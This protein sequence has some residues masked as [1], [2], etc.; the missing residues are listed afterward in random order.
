MKRLIITIT[1]MTTTIATLSAY[2]VAPGF[3]MGLMLGPATNGSGD[4]QAQKQGGGTTLAT[5]RSSQFGTRI[6]MGNKMNDYV[7]LELGLDYFTKI[8]YDSKNVETCNSPNATVKVVDFLVKGDYSLGT[9]FDVFGK[10]GAGYV[11]DTTSGSLNPDPSKAC[12]VTK[13]D[14]HVRPILAVGGSYDLNQ[15][16]LFDLTWTHILVGGTIKSVDHI[17]IGVTYHFVDIYCG[18]FLC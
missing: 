3:Y 9:Y 2:A 4:V 5:P 13:R 12:G 7:G 8:K 14:G 1:A 16:W 10:A 11:Y 6:Y 18:Q 17:A 15:N